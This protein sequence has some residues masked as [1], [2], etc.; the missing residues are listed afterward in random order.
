MNKD[1]ENKIA[2]LYAL[3]W[4]SPEGENDMHSILEQ[5]M[6]WAYADAA[7]V[8]RELRFCEL[9]PSEVKSLK[10]TLEAAKFQHE[11]FVEAAK[12]Q[13]DLCAEAIEERAK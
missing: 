9:G 6:Q 11:V 10:Q 8:C 4:E 12:F 1:A 5:A 3:H 2:E 13:H 7:K